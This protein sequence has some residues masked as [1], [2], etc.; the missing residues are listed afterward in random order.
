M[1]PPYHSLGTIPLYIA[2]LLLA[3]AAVP[4][5]WPQ[6]YQEEGVM[7]EVVADHLRIPW[8]GEF[9]PDGLLFLTA[10]PGTLHTIQDGVVSEVLRLEV[11]GGEGGMLGVALHPNYTDNRLV[12]VYHTSTHSGNMVIRYE[13]HDAGLIQDAVIIKDIPS[14]TYHNGGRIHFGPDG[15]LYV[16]TG[17]AS[18][19]PLSRD[20]GSLAG[21][22]LR[23][24]P[25]G[26]I[27]ADNPFE[28]SPVYAY[29]LRNPQGI[30]WDDA[31]RMVATDHGPSGFYDRAHD[32][33][34]AIV[35]GGDYGWPDSIGDRVVTGTI[36]PIIHS[37]D[38]TWAP[39]GA[40]HLTNSSIPQWNGMILYGALRGEHLGLVS[41]DG[42][43]HQKLFEGEFGRIRAPIQHPDGSV[44][45]LTSNT[46][47]RGS[48]TPDDDRLIRI[49]AHPPIPD[50]L[51]QIAS[52]LWE[53]HRDGTIS[54]TQLDTALA[55]LSGLG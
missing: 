14:S 35:A 48:P 45:L 26:A 50:H 54:R 6:V 3:A 2:A 34:N 33:I 42:S 38:E 30:S 55:H 23:L 37:G 17:D 46:D 32:E 16:A 1:I 11:G 27:P 5:A 24:T 10:R 18:N 21:K 31:G 15:M 9:A 7:V 43:L 13:H 28:G 4:A 22:I 47:G 12:Y 52:L 51:R 36:P 53:W 20:L 29:G 39:S 8:D 49:T 40:V 19:A 44:Y 41:P 25:D